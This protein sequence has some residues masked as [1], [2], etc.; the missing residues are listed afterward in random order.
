MK[1]PEQIAAQALPDYVGDSDTSD[2][3]DWDDMHTF[4][5]AAIEAD[6]AQR[7]QRAEPDDIA[8]NRAAQRF[9][10]ATSGGGDIFYSTMAAKPA[11]VAAL[12]A[13]W[14]ELR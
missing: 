10:E 13:A 5:V 6:R 12:R 9:Y 14:E 11:V 1:T 2:G 3:F 8:F 7:D 4:A